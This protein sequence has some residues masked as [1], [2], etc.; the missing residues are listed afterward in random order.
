MKIIDEKNMKKTVVKELSN[1]L[2]KEQI[3]KGLKDVI[4]FYEQNKS[5][6]EVF[7]DELKRLAQRIYELAGIELKA[8]N[9]LDMCI[10]D[11]DWIMNELKKSLQLED[12]DQVRSRIKEILDYENP[13]PGGFYDNAGEP[14][15][16]PHLV[17]REWVSR[18]VNLH[19][20][21]SDMKPS[22][23]VHLF[24]PGKKGITFK[25]TSLDPN[26][27]YRVKVTYLADDWGIGGVQQ[28][29]ANNYLIHDYIEMPWGE[30]KQ[31]TFD[32]PRSLYENGSLEL[33]FIS[34]KSKYVV[35]S[36]IWLLKTQ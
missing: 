6:Y 21:T 29:F 32:I 12:V 14:G 34:E 1:I 25:Y 2:K 17:Q 3:M 22:Q 4:R 20:V 13:G 8:V 28:L 33:K 24:A 30:V 26:A 5:N 16:Q 10:T 19:N 31:F 11:L 36:E 35:I 23:Y 27:Q 15:Q 18:H 7:K 9:R